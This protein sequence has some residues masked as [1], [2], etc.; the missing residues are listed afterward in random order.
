MATEQFCLQWNNFHCNL[1]SGF[2]NL[3]KNEDLVDVTLACDGKFIQAHKIIL[4]ICSEYFRSLF[5]VNPCKHPIVILKDVNYNDLVS[6]LKF[7]YC[8]KVNVRQEDLPRFLEMAEMLKI[9]GLANERSMKQNSDTRN[10][11]MKERRTFAGEKV[12]CQP[13][14]PTWRDEKYIQNSPS[15]NPLEPEV[16]TSVGSM[17]SNVE[18]SF[19]NGMFERGVYE[20]SMPREESF[21]GEMSNSYP[22][23][24]L[25]KYNSPEPAAESGTTIV[26]P[27]KVLI[28]QSPSATPTT[29]V[30]SSSLKDEAPSTLSEKPPVVD[31]IHPPP[32]SVK[33]AAQMI[34]ETS[35]QTSEDTEIYK[36]TACSRIFKRRESLMSHVDNIHG[37]GRG[38]FHCSLCGRKAKNKHSLSTHMTDYHRRPKK[39]FKQ[40]FP[41]PEPSPKNEAVS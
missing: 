6:I 30:G 17:P 25:V 13:I 22:P 14:W 7:M 34:D 18:Q 20:D 36:C 29:S 11:L 1:S 12:V 31:R 10:S 2:E 40:A 39:K 28:H 9:N 26:K 3:F 15:P 41:A 19:G 21:S 16:E 4:S 35:L 8:G 5:K 27:A 33:P 32:L 24:P 37:Q 23:I 38:P